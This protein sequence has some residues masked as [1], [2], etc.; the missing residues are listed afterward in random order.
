MDDG[1]LPLVI[2]AVKESKEGIRKE[3]F[4]EIC[5]QQETKWAQLNSDCQNYNPEEIAECTVKTQ[6]A[7][8]LCKAKYVEECKAEFDKHV[9]LTEEKDN[10]ARVQMFG[11]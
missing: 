4:M 2:I 11:N 5:R 7:C 3:F 10:A 9:I 1:S 6:D 8:Q